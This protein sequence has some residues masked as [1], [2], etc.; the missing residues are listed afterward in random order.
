MSQANATHEPTL[1]SWIASANAANADFPIQNLP[2][3]VLRRHGSGE[4]LRCAVAIGDHAL[5]LTALRHSGILEVAEQALIELCC[6]SS[7]NRFMAAG[8]HA[9][10][11]FRQ[12]LSRLLRADFEQQETLRQCLLPLD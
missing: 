6:D 7:L 3:A 1:R 10:S 2:F 5:D 11:S 9:W 8:H 4:P 12:T